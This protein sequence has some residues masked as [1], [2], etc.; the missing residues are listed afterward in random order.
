MQEL[1]IMLEVLEVRPV[2]TQLPSTDDDSPLS[3]SDCESLE[4]ICDYEELYHHKA[5]VEEICV[6]KMDMKLPKAKSSNK[7]KP[8]TKIFKDR[9]FSPSLEDIKEV[10]ERSKDDCDSPYFLSM[11]HVHYDRALH[12]GFLDKDTG[13]RFRNEYWKSYHRGKKRSSRRS[14]SW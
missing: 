5:K 7:S 13:R 2:L 8:I 3:M 14:I 9:T 6:L 4:N 1:V 12:G 11:S 10:E